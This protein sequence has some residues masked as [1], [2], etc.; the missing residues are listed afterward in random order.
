MTNIA[1]RKARLAVSPIPASASGQ[2]EE[3]FNASTL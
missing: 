3:Y 2:G 1:A